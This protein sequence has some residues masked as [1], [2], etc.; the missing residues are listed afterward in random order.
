MFCFDVLS[1]GFEA[2]VHGGLQA[3]LMAMVTSL[4]TGLHS[5]FCVG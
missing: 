4:N 5:W 2:T 3:D 1:A